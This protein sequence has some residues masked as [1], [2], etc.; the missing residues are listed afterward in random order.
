MSEL[1]IGLMS[2]TSVDGIDAALVDFS[3]E[4]LELIAFDYQPFAEELKTKIQQISLA[5]QPLLLSDY[6]ALDCELGHL[7]ADAVNKL[8]EKSGI[9]KHKIKAVGSHGQTVYHQP[10]T[11][12]PFSLQIGDPNVITE[13]TGITTVADFRR[14]DMAAFGQGAPLAPAFHQAVFAN[15]KKSVTVVNIGGIANITVLSQNQIIAFDTGT[16]NTLMDYWINKHLNL[17]YDKNGDWGRSGAVIPELLTQFKQAEYFTAP[18]PKSTGKEYFS[19]SWLEQHLSLIESY[20]AED[21][22]ATLCHLTA[23]TINDAIA[24]HAP[25]TEQVLVCGGGA[26]NEYLMELLAKSNYPVS[27]TEDYGVHPDHVEA[28]AFAWLAR[29]TMNNLSGNL[30]QVTGAKTPCVLGGIYPGIRGLF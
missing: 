13:K 2:G 27:S 3:G 12:L 26:H 30:T 7:F 14:R 29:Q 1:Y 16:G 4:K 15:S 9:S 8:L 21:V 20:K 18:P 6:G 28:I 19:V 17:A 23:E 22:Q 5:N 10:N 24:N 25:D 11:A